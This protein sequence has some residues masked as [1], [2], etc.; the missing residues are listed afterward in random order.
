[1][2]NILQDIVY[3]LIADKY[4]QTS[5]QRPGDENQPWKP[6]PACLIEVFHKCNSS[7]NIFSL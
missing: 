1:M 5:S 2:S 3:E 6:M 7:D 4:L